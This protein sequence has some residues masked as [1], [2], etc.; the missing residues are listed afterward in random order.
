MK[1]VLWLAVGVVAFAV[2]TSALWRTVG[3][4]VEQA[5]AREERTVALDVRLTLHDH[6]GSPLSGAPARVVIGKAPEQQP[7]TA[8]YSFVTDATGAH[9]FTAQATIDKAARTRPTN[10]LDSLF[11]TAEQTDHVS[12]GVELGYLT[13]RWLYV[14]DLYRFAQGETLFD[15]LQLYTRNPQG[16]F[17]VKAERDGDSWKIADLGATRLTTQGYQLT[18][19]AFDRKGESDDW[20]LALAFTRAPA[21]V[22]R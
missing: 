9:A 22:V 16:Y 12:V 19:F 17:S 21:P 5:G 7:P 20:T 11:A 2:A 8:G 18:S 14:A 6:D 15:G 3:G 1:I 10:W 4:L 13:Y